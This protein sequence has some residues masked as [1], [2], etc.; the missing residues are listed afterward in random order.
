MGI[1]QSKHGNS[2]KL[3]NVYIKKACFRNEAGFVVFQIFQIRLTAITNMV[4][5]AVATIRPK[6]AISKRSRFIGLMCK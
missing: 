2:F 5:M 1:R 3:E 4:R 6:A